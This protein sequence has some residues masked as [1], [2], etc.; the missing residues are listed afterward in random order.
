[1]PDCFFFSSFSVYL[2][3]QDCSDGAELLSPYSAVCRDV[4]LRL[5]NHQQ[6]DG[7]AHRRKKEKKFFTVLGGLFYYFQKKWTRRKQCKS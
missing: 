7:S 3:R 5:P 2:N 1:L 4:Y 6:S